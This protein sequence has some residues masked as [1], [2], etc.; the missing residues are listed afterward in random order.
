MIS[1]RPFEGRLM[2]DSQ[3]L[4]REERRAIAALKRIALR[5]PESLWLFANG[6]AGI[7]VLKCDN[8]GNRRY[9]EG[10]GIDQNFLV[11]TAYIPNDG[12]DF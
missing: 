1:K 8:D 6:S 2:S 4:T 3:P 9:G 5:W 7:H 11:G 12:G 10:G